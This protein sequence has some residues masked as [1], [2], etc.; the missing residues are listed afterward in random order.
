MNLHRR[1][2]DLFNSKSRSMS[3]LVIAASFTLFACS[4]EHSEA[5]TYDII[6]RGG[7]VYDG[8]GGAPMFADVAIAGDKIVAI[9]DLVH[10]SGTKEIDVR[11]LAVAPGFI[12]MLSWAN[13]TLI[14]D[15]RSQSDLRQGVTL[16]VLGEGPAWG[17]G[18]IK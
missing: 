16:E 13:E 7:T 9:G 12:N 11:G 10:T 1:M 4:N 8:T 14:E 15:G 5:L 3:L 2:R 17:L 18:V 6:L